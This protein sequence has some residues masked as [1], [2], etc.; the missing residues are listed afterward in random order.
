MPL[1]SKPIME[2][3]HVPVPTVLL[4][5]YL[6]L[7]HSRPVLTKALTS[8][9]L[10]ALG[11]LLSQSIER[12]RQ[13]KSS[14]KSVDLVSPLRFAAYGLFFTG[15]L[16][17]YFYLFLEQWAPS[18]VPLAG[19][20]RLLLERLIIAPAFLLLFFIV[21]N[22]LE[23]K[24]LKSLNRT[25]KDSYWS[26]LKMNW[27]VWTPFQFINVNYIPVQFRVLFANIVAFFW[28]TY[29]ASTRKNPD[30]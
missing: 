20:R 26:A 24:N 14:A 7:L 16:S 4:R 6:Q 13:S 9:L 3:E 23:G 2:P 22:L 8:A 28:F 25:L 27:K 1:A 5:T 18:S 21:M 10:S 15:P 29:L 12:R 30:N 11:N 17:H 19:L